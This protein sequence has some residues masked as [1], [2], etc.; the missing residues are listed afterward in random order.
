MLNNL[1]LFIF[2]FLFLYIAVFTIYFVII[3][4]ASMLKQK[5][6]VSEEPYT[7][8]EYKNLIVVI[9]SQNNEKTIVN[10]LEQ[11]NKQDYPKNNYQIHIIV[12]MVHQIN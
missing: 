2:V 7:S 1:L 4:I 6:T 12:L 5:K 9:Y 3:V 10:L 11:L 8:D